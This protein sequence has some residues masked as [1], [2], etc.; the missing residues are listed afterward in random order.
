MERNELKI[1]AVIL[2]TIAALS[3]AGG[4]YALNKSNDL[5]KKV[6]LQ[7]ETLEAAKQNEERKI[8]SLNRDIS[9]I[10]GKNNVLNRELEEVNK[11]LDRKEALL[12]ELNHNNNKRQKAFDTLL[13]SRG[14][15]IEQMEGEN[16]AWSERKATLQNEIN[17]LNEKL[18]TMVPRSSLTADGFRV[19]AVKRN[20]KVTAKAKKVD[21][22]RISFNVP[23]EMGLEGANQ[24]YLSLT[25]MQ[26]KSMYTPIMTVDIGGNETDHRVPVHASTTVNFDTESRHITF[27]ASPGDVEPGVYRA[28]VYSKTGYLGAVEF[29]VR[30]S[31]W[32]F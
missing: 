1:I 24:I 4:I 7:E 17:F 29:Q 20:E 15:L 27:V 26:G 12:R 31:F 3:I 23:A 10:T 18:R 5:A 13:A 21:D 32:F 25:D 19:E 6:A 11:L 2:G 30:D 8:T 22:I 14:D 16:A 9:V 28:S